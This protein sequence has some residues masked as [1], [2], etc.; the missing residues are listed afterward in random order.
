MGS[1]TFAI[2]CVMGFITVVML[3]G[4]SMGDEYM[5]KANIPSKEC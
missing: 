3:K 4:M 2:V 1:L 5:L